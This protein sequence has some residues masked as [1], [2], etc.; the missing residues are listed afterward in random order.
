MLCDIGKA[1]VCRLQALSP[2][3]FGVKVHLFVLLSVYL[4]LLFILDT[5]ADRERNKWW[6]ERGN[7]KIEWKQN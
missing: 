5:E 7:D 1:S 2:L 6:E 4:R 3:S